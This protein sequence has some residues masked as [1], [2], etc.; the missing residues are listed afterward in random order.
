MFWVIEFQGTA[1]IHT[2]LRKG[3]TWKFWPAPLLSTPLPFLPSPPLSSPL[4][5]PPSA[6]K[7]DVDSIKA[8]SPKSCLQNVR[9]ICEHVK[10]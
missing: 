1:T 7:W 4:S 10:E 5:Y 2:H 3:K 9:G 6:L 8:Q